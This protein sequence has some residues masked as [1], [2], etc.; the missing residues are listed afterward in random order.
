MR[1]RTQLSAILVWTVWAGATLS[2]ISYIGN[3]ARNIPFFDDFT[4]VPVMTRHE[5]LSYQWASAQYNEHR[6][7]IPRLVQVMLLRAIPDFRAGLYL[8]AGLL[9]AAAA[10][11][12]VL[13]R[14]LR[15]WTAPSMSSC[16]CRYSPS[17]N[18][19][20]CWSDSP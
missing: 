6:N 2:T 17:G 16:R 1:A 15:G 4:M 7:V 10:A 20:A 18:A 8:N 12:I 14:R 3:Y 19:N 5:P 11:A 13:A 9:S